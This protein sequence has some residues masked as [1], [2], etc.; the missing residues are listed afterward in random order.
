MLMAAARALAD[1]APQHKNPAGAL[2]PPLSESRAVSRAIA[3]AVAAAAER[4][5]LA[6]P[7]SAEEREALIDRKVW[8]P[9]YLPM[10]LKQ[11]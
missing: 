3:L 7:R 9:R 2:L 6:E 11:G 4:E 8:E 10:T 1:R 5:G